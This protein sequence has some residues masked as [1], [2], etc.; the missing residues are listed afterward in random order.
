M[1]NT[2]LLTV[3]I[4]NKC[5]IAFT[6]SVRLHGIMAQFTFSFKLATTWGSGL[7]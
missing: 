2:I 3:E 1:N 5:S 6:Q 4:K 7:S